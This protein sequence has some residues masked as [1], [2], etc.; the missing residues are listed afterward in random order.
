[1][2]NVCRSA[3][4]NIEDGYA[5]LAKPMSNDP[6]YAD[7]EVLVR[8]CRMGDS[9]SWGLL[10]ERFE[11]LVWSSINRV[12]LKAEDAEDTFQKVFLILYRS[13][14]KIESARSLPKWLA[15]TATREAIRQYQ[16]TKSKSLPNLEDFENLDQLLAAEDATVEE[17]ALLASNSD[18]IR[19]AMKLLPGKCPELLAILYSES[20]N[21]YED[22]RAKLGIPSGSIGPTR[23]RCIER[24]RKELQGMNFFD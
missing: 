3:D 5:I 23:A 15:T 12:G 24:L 22:V 7:V 1:M 20:D 4:Q 16:A 9:R 6:I 13:L 14:D 2:K 21:S 18:M 10:V 17:M 19:R 8:K 11:A